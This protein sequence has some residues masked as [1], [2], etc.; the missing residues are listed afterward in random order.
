[1]YCLGKYLYEWFHREIKCIIASCREGGMEQKVP[2]LSIKDALM[3]HDAKALGCN[4]KQTDI[5]DKLVEIQ[6]RQLDMEGSREQKRFEARQ[7]E[8]ERGHEI[9]RV[10]FENQQK[11]Q[12]ENTIALAETF[13]KMRQEME[14]ARGRQLQTLPT[15]DGINMAFEEWAEG[16]EAIVLCNDWSHNQL[17][18]ALPTSLTATAKQSF[19]ALKEDEKKSKEVLI[20]ALRVK[21]APE[22]KSRNKALFVNAR[23]EFGE[24][25]T[26]FM[27]RSKM[28]IRRSGGDPDEQFVI[29]LLKIKVLENM[30]PGDRKILSANSTISEDLENMIR[31][32][33]SMTN[34][35][36]ERTGE[37]KSKFTRCGP[38][39]EEIGIEN[40]E[41]RDHG[42]DQSQEGASSTTPH[43]RMRENQTIF[44]GYCGKCH[45]YGH[46]RRY[47]PL[48]MI[49]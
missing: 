19:D 10:L 38:V 3:A 14:K 32:A 25:M 42:R 13:E 26:A 9:L 23:K 12:R 24:S 31:T 27:D 47:C 33:D 48:R 29:E 28:Y 34:S 18:E 6:T 43:R 46:S 40:L 5:L 2:E 44:Q 35:K 36:A 8:E 17:L 4:Q 21:I 37:I 49:N 20:N 45:Q 22:S 16:V 1:M 11:F 30:Q 41:E 39:I 7:Q 15:Y